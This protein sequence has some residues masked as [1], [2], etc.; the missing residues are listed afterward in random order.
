M[1]CWYVHV[2][3]KRQYVCQYSIGFQRAPLGIIN[4][5]EG[6]ACLRDST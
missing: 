2:I 5:L 3:H 1:S 6:V 4:C